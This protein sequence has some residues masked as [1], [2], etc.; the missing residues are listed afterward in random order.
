[1]TARDQW[2]VIYLALFIAAIN[3]AMFLTVMCDADKA[4]AEH[5]FANPTA[6]NDETNIPYDV[7]LVTDVLTH[8]ECDSLVAHAESHRGAMSESM[9]WDDH[10]A[11]SPDVKSK[12]RTSTQLWLKYDDP[13]V[14]EIARKLRNVAAHFT[15]VYDAQNFEHVQLAR[16]EKDQHYKQHYD[17]CTNR[18]PNKKLCRVATLLVYLNDDFTGGET[19]FPKSNRKITPKKGAGV[20]F[21]NV[22]TNDPS[23]PELEY[24]LHAG[25]PVLSGGPKYIAN[26][27]VNC[28]SSKKLS[29]S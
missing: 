4:S 27:W 14:G 21:Y 18:C 13:K 3:F 17:A 8:E 5:F 19:E 20:L 24:S 29:V 16:Y 26:V 11:A 1:M 15:G 2:A 12:H 25:L 23:Y 9:V 6:A 10:N 22:D 7:R 28:P